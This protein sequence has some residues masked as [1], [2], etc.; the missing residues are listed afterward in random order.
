MTKRPDDIN[1]DPEGGRALERL[2]MFEQA[3]AL[4]PVQKKLP[5]AKATAKR[6]A[7]KKRR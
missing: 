6:S 2:R 3:R 4:K 7:R 5:K 1:P